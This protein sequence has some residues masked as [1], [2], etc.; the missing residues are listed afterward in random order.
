MGNSG[1]FSTCDNHTIFSLNY[2]L[3]LIEFL[4]NFHQCQCP[5]IQRSIYSLFEHTHTHMHPHM[6]TY[7]HTNTHEHTHKM[8]MVLSRK[9][10]W[11]GEVGKKECVCMCVC[12]CVYVCVCVCVYVCV[13]MCVCVCM[14]VC[15][16]VCVFCLKDYILSPPSRD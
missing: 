13:C 4:W 9:Q 15:V 2:S 5:H 16:C 10:N 7:I 3:L 14:S 11:G 1:Q 12:V 8:H 6:H